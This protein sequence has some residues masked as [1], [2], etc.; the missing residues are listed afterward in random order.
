[1]SPAVGGRSILQQ[2]PLVLMMWRSNAS[3]SLHHCERTRF[4][5]RRYR[6]HRWKHNGTIQPVLNMMPTPSGL[7]CGLCPSL[8]EPAAACL[9]D[10]GEFSMLA[11]YIS[12][13]SR[14]MI[15]QPRPVQRTVWAFVLSLAMKQNRASDQIMPKS[16]IIQRPS[17]MSGRA[18]PPASLPEV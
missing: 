17:E 1:M 3:A 8:Q 4:A 16:F 12:M 13:S 10:D 14:L 15:A 7:I 2:R 18:L 11:K 6:I 9:F 5:H